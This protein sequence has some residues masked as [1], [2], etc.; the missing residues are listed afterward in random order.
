MNPRPPFDEAV[1]TLKAFL[2]AQGHNDHLLWLTRDRITG[3]RNHFWIYRPV[4]LHSEQASRDYYESIR[5]TPTSIRVDVL[6]EID[7]HSLTYV[8]DFGGDGGHLNF[9][10]STGPLT[11]TSVSN[12][13]LWL[14]LRM[15]T[16]IRGISPFLKCTQM[17][18]NR[19]EPGGSANSRPAGV[20]G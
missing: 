1:Q 2:R 10:I 7:S 18:Q 16:A 17:T 20:H 14:W 5:S 8:Q 13:I 15:Y 4:E 19:I 12:P 9:G 11:I 3:F 6:G